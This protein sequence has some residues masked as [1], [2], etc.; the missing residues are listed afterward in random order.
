[1]RRVHLV[2]HGLPTL[3]PDLPPS[4]WHLDPAGLPAIDALRS[5]G[6]LPND[7]SWFSSPEP[8]AIDTARRLTGCVVTAV[9]DLREHERG[10]T[11]WFDDPD[12]WSGVIRRV[13]DEPDRP[14]LVGWEPLR[15]TSQ[16]V[17]AAVR[18]ILDEHPSDEI[19][20]VG[21]GTAWAALT[22]SLLDAEPDLDAWEKLRM[23]DLWVLEVPDLPEPPGM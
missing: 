20:L 6:R 19:V 13:F 14:A 11:P 15:R 12:E 17:V 8:K 18:R 16:R 22:A 21:H 2:R 23:P 9:D 1:M 4:R 5:S 7:A 3:Q 10:A